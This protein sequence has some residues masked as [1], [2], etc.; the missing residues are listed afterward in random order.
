MNQY[1]FLFDLDSTI[2]KEEILPKLAHDLGKEEEMRALTESTMV[3]EIPFKES[4]LKRVEI[5]KEIPVSRVQKAIEEIELNPMV[6]QFI[7][8]HKD[9]CYIVTGNLDVWIKR[10]LKK[11]GLENQ[12][13]CSKALVVNDRLTS[14]ISVIDKS[15]ICEQFVQD[16]VAV[17]DGNNDAD[18]I[19][20]A[21][22]GIG[23]GAVR[24]IAF[25]LLENA[26]YAFY[27]DTKLYEFLNKINGGSNT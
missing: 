13:Y 14:V 27:S 15:L 26:D 8:E 21:S 22:I 16:F 11:L 10:L 19:K 1:I 3:G 5:L 4:F 12:C 18:M 7:K 24:P 6:V 23:F 17:G 2:T 20:K 25:A 9:I